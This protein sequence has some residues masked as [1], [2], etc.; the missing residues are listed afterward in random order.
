MVITTTGAV[1]AVAK[2]IPEL[3][4]K[5]TGMLLEFQLQM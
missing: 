3:E 5:L 1:K 2:A 4:G